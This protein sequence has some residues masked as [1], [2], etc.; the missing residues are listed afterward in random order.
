LLALKV[1]KILV[2]ITWIGLDSMVISNCHEV[3][4]GQVIAFDGKNLRGTYDKDKNCVAI[5]MVS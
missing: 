2:K 4:E 3:T 1:G 5:H